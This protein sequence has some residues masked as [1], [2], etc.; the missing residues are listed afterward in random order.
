MDS[1][2]YGHIGNI[3]RNKFLRPDSLFSKKQN[4]RHVSKFSW[5]VSHFQLV[6]LATQQVVLQSVL[7]N[8]KTKMR[9]V[10]RFENS[11]LTFG[12]VLEIKSRDFRYSNSWIEK[13][14]KIG[15]VCFWFRVVL[16]NPSSCRV[17][18]LAQGFFLVILKNT[19]VLL[20]LVLIGFW[21]IVF[22]HNRY[23]L[24]SSQSLLHFNV[25]RRINWLTACVVSRGSLFNRQFRKR[26]SWFWYQ[27]S[28]QNTQTIFK[29]STE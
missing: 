17:I 9:F 22:I 29:V 8:L 3:Q 18:L 20:Q 7:P 15:R 16:G 23:S 25:N 10:F 1:I 28:I 19:L 4:S 27:A 26:S 13:L 14:H 6:A 21:S 2:C 5:T 12:W 11:V 24:K